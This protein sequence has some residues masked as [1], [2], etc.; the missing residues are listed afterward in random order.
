MNGEGLIY[1][2]GV[3]NED[4]QNVFLAKLTDSLKSISNEIWVEGDPSSNINRLSRI[5]NHWAHMV[6]VVCSD[7]YV[8]LVEKK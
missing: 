8:D 6:I 5:I 3:F 2:Y 7:Q 1:I 4:K